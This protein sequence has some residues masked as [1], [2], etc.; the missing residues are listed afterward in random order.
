MPSDAA[1]KKAAAKKVRLLS[2]KNSLDSGMPSLK[3]CSTVRDK[4]LSLQ[5]CECYR[6]RLR[7]PRHKPP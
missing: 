1:R 3:V 2:E 5:A 7:N 4:K 6:Q